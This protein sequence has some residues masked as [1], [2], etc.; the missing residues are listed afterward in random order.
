[1]E[2]KSDY[3]NWLDAKSVLT[4]IC[5][6]TQGTGS[7]LCVSGTSI[8]DPV[9]ATSSLLYNATGALVSGAVLSRWAT[10]PFTMGAYPFAGMPLCGQWMRYLSFLYMSVCDVHVVV[11]CVCACLCRRWRIGR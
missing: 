8:P 7:P 5:T 1:M 11:V 9:N 4:Q 10:D 6:A 3:Q 2:A